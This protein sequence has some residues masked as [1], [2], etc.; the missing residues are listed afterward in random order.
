MRVEESIEI[1]RSCE[2]VWS[3]V[4]DPM[5]DPKW[6]PKVIS[7]Q[8]SGPGGWL[9]R[10]RPVPLRPSL[11]LAVKHLE[12]DAPSR[13]TMREEDATSTFEVQY[14]LEPT[15]IGTRFTQV[16]DFQWKKLPRVLHKTFERGVRRDIQGQL[17]AL[18][19]VLEGA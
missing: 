15:S 10:H 14:R 17:H 8:P 4:V 2:E 13:L 12:L 7:V 18:K 1:A 16:S 6:C 19:G 3:F 5:N 11:E 9:V